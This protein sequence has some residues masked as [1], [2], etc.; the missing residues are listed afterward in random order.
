[1]TVGGLI[2][3]GIIAAEVVTAVKVSKQGKRIEKL[4][5][6]VEKKKQS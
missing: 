6:G 4:E 5:K 1:M 3:L 2:V